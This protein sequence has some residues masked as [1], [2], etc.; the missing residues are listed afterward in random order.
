ML[1]W[2]VI[3]LVVWLIRVDLK[4]GD[5]AS[6]VNAAFFFGILTEH[7][8]GPH[9][10]LEQLEETFEEQTLCSCMGLR[11]TQCRHCCRWVFQIFSVRARGYPALL[12]TPNN[13]DGKKTE[14]VTGGPEIEF[15]ISC[16]TPSSLGKKQTTAAVERSKQNDVAILSRVV[17]T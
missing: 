14:L 4:F 5:L 7:R 9:G 10:R 3:M 6:I 8:L 15:A 2:L 12:P 1:E 11:W 17:S 16:R 13:L